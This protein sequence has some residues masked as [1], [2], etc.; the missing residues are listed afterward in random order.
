MTEQT[1]R[2]QEQEDPF[3]EWVL[4]SLQYVKER[5]QLFVGGAIAIVV[6]LAMME[7]ARNH[8]GPLF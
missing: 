5:A 1:N 3:L 7:F 2:Q 6:A 8:R 4:T